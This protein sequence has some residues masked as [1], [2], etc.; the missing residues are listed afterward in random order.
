MRVRYFI[1]IIEGLIAKGVSQIEIAKALDFKKQNLTEVLGK[2]PGKQRQNLK[3]EHLPGLLTLCK[4]HRVGPQSAD[5]LLKIIERE[6]TQA[7]K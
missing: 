1:D 2:I 5:G 7:K 4:K 3:D 6:K